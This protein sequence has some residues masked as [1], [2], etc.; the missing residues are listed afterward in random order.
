VFDVAE[1]AEVAEVCDVA[2]LLDPDET[3]VP[4]I[5]ASQQEVYGADPSL[6]IQYHWN[7]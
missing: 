2:E 6:K 3:A 4:E 1:V 5:I 7:V